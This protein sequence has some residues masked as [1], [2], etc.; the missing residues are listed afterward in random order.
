VGK[1]EVKQLG[2]K[3]LVLDRLEQPKQDKNI[4][5]RHDEPTEL[6][7]EGPLSYVLLEYPFA[8][9]STVGR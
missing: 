2:K 8:K 3:Y 9:V 1:I 6:T 4:L 5:Y 7:K